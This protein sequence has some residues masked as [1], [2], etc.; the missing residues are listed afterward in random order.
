MAHITTTII[1]PVLIFAAVHICQTL[2]TYQARSSLVRQNKC[3]A[4]RKYPHKDPILGLDLFYTIVQSARKGHFLRSLVE[5]HEAYGRTFQSTSF[6]KTIINTIEPKI[7]STVLATAS[8]NFGVGPIRA[9]PADPFVGRGV[10]TTDGASWAHSRGLI[11]P[12]FA[13][14]QVTDLVSLKKHV[15]RLIELIPIDGSTIDMQALFSRLVS[16]SNCL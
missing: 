12:S 9:P 7:L 15:D 5:R 2:R 16:L 11:R 14:A 4:P 3:K 6:G 13:R 10:F 8:D 1:I